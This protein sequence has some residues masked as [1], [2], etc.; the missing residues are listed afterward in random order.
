MS[1]ETQEVSELAEAPAPEQA[2]TAA[3]ESEI[4]RRKKSQQNYL[5][6]SLKKK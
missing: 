2:A 3:P 1:E 4:L 6:S 5:K